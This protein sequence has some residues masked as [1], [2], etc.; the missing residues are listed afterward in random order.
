VKEVL[1]LTQ[2]DDPHMPP[3]AE[4]IRSRGASIICFNLA[5]FP[6]QVTLQTMFDRESWNGVLVYKS[7]HVLLNSLTSIWWRRPKRYKAPDAYSPGERTFLEE[8]ANRGIIGVL[9]SLIFHNTLWVSR[10]HNIRRADLKPLQ[11][12]SAQ[13]LGLRVPRTLVTNDPSII[14]EFYESCHGSVILKA[15]SR[16][17]IEDDEQKR[18]IYTSKV[19]PGHLL[20]LEGVRVTAH[21]FQ[22][23]IPKRVE[24]RVVVIGQQVFAAEI[25]SQHSERAKIDF[26]Q[27]YEDI[28]YDVHILPEDIKTKIFSLVRLFDLQFSSMDFIVTP[29]GEYVFLDLNP[30]GQ[31]YWLQ[32]RLSERFPVKEAMA[33]LLVYPKDYCL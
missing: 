20:T 22:E 1:I 32:M 13:H 8:E 9:E 10:S 15:V 30:N 26:R 23:Y 31:F 4:E 17:S 18:F 33:N 27:G 2:S 14:Q 25:H 24:L 21:L 12:A 11:L 5:D 28:T 3:I 7:H 6:E 29:Q 19:L 16:G